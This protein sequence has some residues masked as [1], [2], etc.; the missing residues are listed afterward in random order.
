MAIIFASSQGWLVWNS[1][2]LT[3]ASKGL[4][5][6]K[7]FEPSVTLS[8]SAPRQANQSFSKEANMDDELEMIDQTNGV[9][10]ALHM[11]PKSLD[12]RNQPLS[13]LQDGSVFLPKGYLYDIKAKV[14]RYRKLSSKSRPCTNGLS[15]SSWQVRWKG[16]QQ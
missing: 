10:F 2:L 14:V 13:A 8:I 7:K 6:S 9:Y 16:A 3:Q 4:Y 15:M 1:T 11:P 5:R 12:E